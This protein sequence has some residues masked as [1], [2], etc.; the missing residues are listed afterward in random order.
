MLVI[1]S[2]TGA[3]VG[4]AMTKGISLHIGLNA[5]DLGHYQGWSGALR[6]C[7][8]DADDMR[9]I[10]SGRGFRSQLLLT[11]A[12]TRD[13]VRGAIASAAAELAAGDILFISYS[14]HGGQVPDSNGDEDDAQDETWCLYDGQL[15]DDELHALWATFAPGVRILVV[16]DS[17]HSGTITR[18]LYLSALAA[19]GALH[20]M[21]GGTD[22]R[23]VMRAMP[24]NVAQRVYRANRA[25]YDHLQDGIAGDKNAPP[26]RASV[27]LISGCQDN[28]QS[29]DGTFNGLF[30]SNLLRVWKQGDFTGDYR[31]FHKAIVARMPPIQTPNYFRVGANDSAFDAQP[32]FTV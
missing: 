15:I 23:P 16:S 25:F 17:C 1:S 26:P 9:S 21:V 6:A 12:A 14:G 3:L 11:S 20:A 2:W 22:E 5:V 24:D 7:E 29:A 10:A 30:T 19:T 4:D 27:L 18:E 13:A 32:P 31:A 8:A 28:Q